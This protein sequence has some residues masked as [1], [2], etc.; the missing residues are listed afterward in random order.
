MANLIVSDRQLTKIKK[1]VIS[2]LD[3][4]AGARSSASYY[5]TRDA[6]IEAVHKHVEK[7]YDLGKELPLILASQRGA[8]GFF[9]QS[10][11]LNEFENTVDGGRNTI[12]APRDWTHEIEDRAIEACLHNLDTNAGIPY[13]LRMFLEFRDR[14]INNARSRR[15]ALDFILGHDNLEFISVKYRN[16]LEQIL[17]HLWGE[18]MRGVIVSI[19]K[20]DDVLSAKESDL[21]HKHVHRYSGFNSTELCRAAI[22]YIFKEIDGEAIDA[23]LTPIF[24]EVEAARE[25]VNQAPHVPEEILFGL[26]SNPD[27]PQHDQMWSTEAQRT[28]TMQAI[29][30]QNVVETANQAVRKTKQERERGIERDDK[31]DVI[32]RATDPI[33]ILKTVYAG[34]ASDE[35]LER[36][37]ELAR[38]NAIDDFP[39]NQ[40]GLIVD[41]SPSMSGHY[42]ESAKTPLAMTEFLSMVIKES[43]GS[44]ITVDVHHTTNLARAFVGLMRL[45]DGDEDD[46]FGKRDAIFVLSDGYENDPY[47]G[48]FEDVLNIYQRE[49][50]EIPVYHI[51]P[52]VGAEMH[53]Q[54]RPLGDGIASIS[55]N[56]RNLGMQMQA[57]MLE[58][59]TRLWLEKQIKRLSN[60]ANR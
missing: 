57:K 53:A 21:W 46:T 23:D 1:A 27:H 32:E 35:L 3:V 18:S 54:T 13:V 31:S 38:E 2:G 17:T 14:G 45:C 47:E 15:F 34:E 10:A 4:A 8:T 51:S 9:I 43:T 11:L 58:A 50:G 59:D 44:A 56:Y 25:D 48:A 40:I 22:L 7:I 37:G 41:H 55:A 26:L 29:R 24:A 28:E 12:V 20:K 19:A 33:A 52:I 42:R 49:V 39:Y 60:G 6:Q 30:N 5:H 36:L 16:K